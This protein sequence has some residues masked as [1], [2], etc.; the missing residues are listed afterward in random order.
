MTMLISKLILTHDHA[1]FDALA[2]MFAAAKLNPE[3]VPILPDQLNANVS[4]FLT[5][6]GSGLPFVSRSQVTPK[7][8]ELLNGLNRLLL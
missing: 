3:H 1:D 4:R 8:I 6:Y 7:R 5:L 2:A